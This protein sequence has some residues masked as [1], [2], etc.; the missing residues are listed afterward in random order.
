[1]VPRLLLATSSPD[2]WVQGNGMD[3]DLEAAPEYI[4]HKNYT[5]KWGHASWW[6][7]LDQ[8]LLYPVI[9]FKSLQLIW[10]LC[11]ARWNFM[12]RNPKVRSND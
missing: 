12:A 4:V 3:C 2:S 6:P 1:M 9:S 5:S 10:R 7:L 8:L 11:Y